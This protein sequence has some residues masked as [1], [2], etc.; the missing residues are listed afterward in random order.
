MISGSTRAEHLPCTVCP[1]SVVLIAQA[2]FFEE[3]EQIDTCRHTQT[4]SQTPMNTY[5]ITDALA[6]TSVAND[7]TV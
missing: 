1:P 7:K 4:Q 5:P 2:I 3:C 6:T